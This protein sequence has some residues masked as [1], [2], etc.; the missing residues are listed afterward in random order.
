MPSASRAARRRACSAGCGTGA[1][2]VSAMRVGVAGPLGDLLDRAGLHHLA[3]VE[4]DHPLGEEPDD[5]E[6]VGDEQQRELAVVAQVGEQVEHLGL[7][8]QV[9]GADRLVEHDDLRVADQGAGDRDPLPLPAGELRGV[10]AGRVGGQAD[11]GQRLGDPPLAARP[12][13]PAAP[14]AAR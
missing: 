12:S 9:E 3:A 14:A 2:A 5:A 7:G 8:G 4:H 1:A 11:G 6:V 10:A 13:A